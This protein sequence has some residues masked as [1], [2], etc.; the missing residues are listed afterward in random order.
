M[1]REYKPLRVTKQAHTTLKKQA[2]K[3]GMK[4]IDYITK[5]VLGEKK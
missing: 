1:K 5:L 3:E 2:K 4:L